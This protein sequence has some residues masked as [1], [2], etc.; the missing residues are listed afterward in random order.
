MRQLTNAP[1]ARR[2][3]S[4]ATSLK[5]ALATT[6][7]LA[8]APN[9]ADALPAFEM[10]A[11]V[12]APGGKYLADGD[13]AA[14]IGAA[15][16]SRSRVSAVEEVW[17]ESNVCVA[18]TKL[19][20]FEQAGKACEAALNLASAR[21]GARDSRRDLHR[22]LA[23]VHTN[24]AILRRATGDL[25]AAELDMRAALTLA[26]D[27][28]LVLANATAFAARRDVMAASHRTP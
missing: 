27:D 1:V 4:R 17:L 22:R 6:L 15:T 10:A 11:A 16:A 2:I 9:I 25:A 14:A 21:Y 28:A 23:L 7:S 3:P 13:Y 26:P 12:D 5:F 24:R 18:H 8:I 20:Q 19:G